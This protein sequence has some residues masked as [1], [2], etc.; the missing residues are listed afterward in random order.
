MP[1]PIN[2]LR[3]QNFRRVHVIRLAQ[4]EYPPLV[5]VRPPVHPVARIHP[6]VRPEFHV[7]RQYSPEK[8]RVV[9]HL[10]S[11]AR[12]LHRKSVNPAVLSRAPEI[13][14]EKMIP[15]RRGKSRAR[16]MRQSRR[17][18]RDM[19]HRRHD[20]RRL[21]GKLQVPEFLGIPYPR[22]RGVAEL[23]RD[24]PAAVAAFHEIHQPR[25]VAVIAIIVS[26]E[27]DRRNRQTPAFADSAIRIA[28]TSRLLP[29]WLQRN[30]VPMSG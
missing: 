27:Q 12:P 24:A 9:H 14:Q 18:A 11:R 1:S 3:P 30:T 13:A 26:R 4:P 23:V 28:N 15:I 10:K 16:I 6:P 21:P 20:I 29:S 25:R 2:S 17:P 7:R 22:R 8:F 19:P 5:L